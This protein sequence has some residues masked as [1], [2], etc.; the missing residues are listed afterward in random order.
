MGCDISERIAWFSSTQEELLVVITGLM[1]FLVS[2]HVLLV[3][4]SF[5]AG[6][7]TGFKILK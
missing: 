4:C 1:K 3:C 5:K 2:R 6:H 7:A